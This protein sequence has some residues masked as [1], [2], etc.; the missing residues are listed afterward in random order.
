MIE[1]DIIFDRLFASGYVNRFQWKNINKDTTKYQVS[2][3][4]EK[5]RLNALHCFEIYVVD[6]KHYLRKTELKI[7]LALHGIEIDID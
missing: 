3:H 1:A 7:F 2:F 6:G 5:C 4:C